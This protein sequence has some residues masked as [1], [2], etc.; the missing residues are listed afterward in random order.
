MRVAFFWVLVLMLLAVAVA[1]SDK[2]RILLVSLLPAMDSPVK[3]YPLPGLTEWRPVGEKRISSSDNPNARQVSFGRALHTDT[4]GSDEISTVIAPAFELDWIA[5]PNMFVTEG[6]VFDGAGNIYFCPVYPT[7]NA[8]LVSLEPAQGKRRWVVEGFSLGC[9]TPYVLIDPDTGEDVIYL[10]TYDRAMALTTD[11]KVLWDV[12]TGLPA[13]DPTV[14]DGNKHSFGMN[15]LAHYDALVAVMGDGSVYVL[16]RKT[17]RSLLEKP[18]VM[19][20]DK[21]GVTNFSLP[22]VVSLKANRDAAHMFGG[23]KSLNGQDPISA[24]LH[25]AAGEKQKVTNFFSIDSN[26]GRL[27]IAATLPDEADG[28]VDG[29]AD[30][31]AL[32]GL[33]LEKKGKYYQFDVHSVTQVPGGTASTPA[34]SA[35]GQRV[36]IA[37]AFDSVYAIDANTGEQI[38]SFNVGS[39]VAGSLTIAADNG[40]IYANVRTQIVKLFD[41]GDHAEK[42]WVSNLDMFEA[43]PFQSNFKALGAEVGAN[44]IAFTGA[45][46]LNAGKKKFPLKIGAGI[47]DRE[48]GKVRY[49][50]EGGEDSVS[51]MVTGPE[52]GLYIG[53]SPLRRVLARAVLGEAKSPMSVQGG[54]TRFKPVHNHLIVRDALWAAAGRARNAATLSNSAVVKQDVFQINQLLDQALQALPV[55]RA[56]GDID[57]ALYDAMQ[58][59]V[60]TA[61]ESVSADASQLL[62]MAEKLETLSRRF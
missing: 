15:Y 32:Y 43:G 38:W 12:P 45:V 39:K 61:K 5:E 60:T 34:V 20:G 6:P 47:L 8:L 19:P 40:E 27:W 21:T 55:A 49:F 59:M 44:G 26:T 36:Y 42:A 17:G 3:T 18:Y 30:Y 56:E 7:E 58:R 46:G 35:D 22:T 16:D 24:V 9:G 62:A 52:G 54:I 33:N 41:R 28:K 10:G 11:G 13:L 25:I 23:Q 31:A 2:A 1:V 53:N 57:Q 14:I 4:H 29:F 51:S 50:V 48:T 37:D